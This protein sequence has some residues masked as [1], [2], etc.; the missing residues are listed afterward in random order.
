LTTSVAAKHRAP[1]VGS[2]G[3]PP[4]SDP[5]PPP[6]RGSPPS[7]GVEVPHPS[8]GAGTLRPTSSRSRPRPTR[9]FV[10]RQRPAPVRTPPRASSTDGLA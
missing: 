1:L 7:V 5:R 2:W 9:G 3:F 6:R 10:S 4:R 8:D